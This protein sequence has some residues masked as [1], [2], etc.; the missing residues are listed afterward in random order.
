MWARSSGP[1]AAVGVGF[2]VSGA[3]PNPLPRETIEALA[4]LA[5]GLRLL[6]RSLPILS[7]SCA[8]R[9]AATDPQ[10]T[11]EIH[12]ADCSYQ[13][14]DQSVSH[15]LP[16]VLELLLLRCVLSS[17]SLPPLPP[18]YLPFPSSTNYR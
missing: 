12:R 10:Y 7:A 6:V 11:V 14:R 5:A 13:T 3:H 9:S 8:A 2:L 18:F 4:L 1:R 17:S 15:T 16:G